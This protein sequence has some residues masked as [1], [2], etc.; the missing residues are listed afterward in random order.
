MKVF[1]SKRGRVTLYLACL[2]LLIVV[3]GFTYKSLP[4]E[5]KQPTKEKIYAL[6]ARIEITSYQFDD[7]QNTVFADYSDKKILAIGDSQTAAYRW[8][9]YLARLIH[10][11]I[12]THAKGGIGM[13]A[14]VDGDRI[15]SNTDGVG[16]DNT[17]RNNIARLSSKEVGDKDYIIVMGLYN[18]NDCFEKHRGSRYDMYPTD[19]TYCGQF[20]YM[21]KRIKEELSWANNTRCKLILATPHLF[22]K[23]PYADKDA[24]Y[25]RNIGML[26]TLKVLSVV[27]D[28]EFC[29]LTQLAGIDSTNWNVFQSGKLLLE[30]SPYY[31]MA[32]YPN[33]RDNLHLNQRGH[34]KIAVAIAK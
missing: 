33:N 27:N 12:S 8:Q 15:L 4:Y 10:A 26:D 18:E 17:G 24:Y 3:L 19:T 5:Y 28:M 31:S 2:L 13:L 32:Q 30:S 11:D 21:V 20:N 23:Y 1:K 22:G 9:Y 25:Y 14:M 34:M 16:L 29:D 7:G 6:K